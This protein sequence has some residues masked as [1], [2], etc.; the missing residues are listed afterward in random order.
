MNLNPLLFILFYSTICF[1]CKK[2]TPSIETKT[3]YKEYLLD[4]IDAQNIPALASLIFAE[5]KIL[6]EEYLGKSNIDQGISLESNHVFLLAS[7]SKVITATALL[8]LHEDG[9]FALDD[10]I[11][12]YLDFNVSVPNYTQNITFR[13]LL[14]HTSGIADGDELDNHYY[15]NMDSPISLKTYL[16]NYLT[17]QGSYY[18]ASQNFHDFE[19]GSVSEYSNTGNALIGLLVEEISGMG[20]NQYCKQKIFLPLEMNNTYWKLDEINGTIV[21]PYNFS[22]G[23]YTALEHYTNT[24][25]PNGGLRSSAQDLFKLLSTFCLKGKYN[26]FELLSAETIDKMTSL[27]IPELSNDMGLHLFILNAENDLWG[28][29][30]GEKGVATI[31]AYNKTTKVGAIILTNQGEA[32]LDEILEISYKFGLKLNE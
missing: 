17:P 7:I 22:G 14:T 30:G 4:E 15:E 24:D 9:L 20:F 8:Q 31:M 23:N 16:K 28:H 19:P 29:D 1:S 26:N 18:N 32:D 25:Y 27:Q 10:K 3:E 12:D 5:D 13:M 11:N 2:E 6:H 21:Q